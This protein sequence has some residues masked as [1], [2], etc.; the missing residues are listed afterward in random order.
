MQKQPHK[1]PP[2][3]VTF[4]KHCISFPFIIIFNWTCLNIFLATLRSHWCI[5]RQQ[6]IHKRLLWW[7]RVRM[8]FYRLL[9]DLVSLLNFFRSCWCCETFHMYVTFRYFWTDRTKPKKRYKSHRSFIPKMLLIF[10]F[11]AL[12]EL[13]QITIFTPKM[14]LSPSVLSR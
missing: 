5:L 2:W 4:F 13:I 1:S 12:Q 9:K 3:I 8:V 11:V 10:L 14:Y 7:L 6:D